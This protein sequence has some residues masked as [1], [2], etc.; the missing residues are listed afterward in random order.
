MDEIQDLLAAWLP[1]SLVEQ[2]QASD[3]KIESSPWVLEV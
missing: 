1:D 2:M 3:A